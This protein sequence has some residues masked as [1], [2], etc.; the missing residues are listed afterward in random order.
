VLVFSSFRAK[1]TCKASAARA[2]IH[3]RTELNLIMS[4]V[5]QAIRPVLLAVGLVGCL[6][7][8]GAVQAS[9]SGGVGIVAPQNPRGYDSSAVP[10]ATFGRTLRY[11]LVGE[12]VK[13]LQTW[14]TEVG[15]RVP[16]T[17]RFG[18]ITRRMVKAFQRAHGLQASGIA[19][20]K[21]V[22]ALG[23]AV[24]GAA[25]KAATEGTGGSTVGAPPGH[26]PSGASW[27]FP[28]QPISRV[29]DPSNWT[30]DQ[31]VDIGTVNNACGSRVVEVAMT[32]GTIV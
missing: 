11:G 13:T 23:L 4:R 5:R 31:G 2:P 18:P 24:A 22:T 12:D 17:G 6:L 15:Y 20:N 32:S 29:L 3:H 19:G 25:R 14:L 30:L 1:R 9:S 10:Y 21:T 8:P 7:L 26:T 28:L 27:V 16:E